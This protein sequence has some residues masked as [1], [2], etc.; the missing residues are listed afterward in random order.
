MMFRRCATLAL[1]MVLAAPASAAA[2][3]LEGD[4]AREASQPDLR[5]DVASLGFLLGNWKPLA[6]QTV[7]RAVS[8]SRSA[9]RIES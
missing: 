6:L 1:A 5:P 8:H 2:Q 9:S 7:K 4:N 3:C